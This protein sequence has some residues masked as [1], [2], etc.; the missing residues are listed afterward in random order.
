MRTRSSRNDPAS[1]NGGR[2][3]RGNGAP[4]AGPENFAARM[5]RWSAHHRKKAIFGWLAFVVIA[6]AVGNAIGMN[7]LKDAD[8][9]VRDSGRA[10]KTVDNAFPKKAEETVL[11]QSKKLKASDPAFVAGVGDVV[12]RL[13]ATKGV[14]KVE[15][16]YAR[17]KRANIS[18]DRHSALVDFE[19]PGD[20]DQVETRVEAPLAAVAALDGAHPDLRIE[21]FG[22]AS[23]SKAVSKKSD[24]DFAKAETTSLP[25]TLV[26]LLIAFGTL[27]AAGIPLLLAITG[28]V[29]TLGLIG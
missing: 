16:P 2:F 3:H 10:D 7:S 27:V 20:T 5:G 14:R 11:V 15:S 9:G 1:S 8:S 28:V 29:A 26:I 21:E 12:T 17:D 19:V 13:E 6:F 22:D 23:A 18:A 4:P 24:D 25:L